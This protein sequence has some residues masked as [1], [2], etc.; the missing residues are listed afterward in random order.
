V[1][2]K[3]EPLPTSLFT[4]IVPPHPPHARV[5]AI[6]DKQVT[7]AALSTGIPDM[8]PSSLPSYATRKKA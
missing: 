3:V 5:M 2:A 7:T 8:E 6:T 1:N 4:Q